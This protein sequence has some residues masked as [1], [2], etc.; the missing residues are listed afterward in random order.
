MQAFGYY[1]RLPHTEQVVVFEMARV[2]RQ[3]QR[4][5]DS[6]DREELDSFQARRRMTNAELELEPPVKQFALGMSFIDRYKMEA[7]SN[8]S[9]KPSMR[10]VRELLR[11]SHL[12]RC[13]HAT[14]Q[15]GVESASEV[16]IELTLCPSTQAML[17]WL[18]EQ[19]EMRDD[20]SMLGG[21][22]CPLAIKQGREYR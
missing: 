7:G 12:F 4:M 18:R 16:D 1:H 20:W 13:I 10:H 11:T 22:S 3:N 14:S 6:T 8:S 2:A 17:S 21:A 5:L 15:R 19:I 9:F